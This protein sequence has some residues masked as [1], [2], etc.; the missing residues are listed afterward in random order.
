MSR[1]SKKNPGRLGS[2]I[3]DVLG[4]HLAKAS[5]IAISGAILFVEGL[6]A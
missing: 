1:R 3:A 2:I 5:Y 6:R 4:T